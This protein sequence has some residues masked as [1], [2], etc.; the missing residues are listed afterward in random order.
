VIGAALRSQCA[1]CVAGRFSVST[2]ST[3]CSACPPG[4]STSGAEGAV[5]CAYCARGFASAGGQGSCSECEK[6]TYA[7]GEGAARCDQC[8]PGRYA[9]GAKSAECHLCPL[10]RFLEGVGASAQ[11]N[12]TSCT[13]LDKRFFSLAVG[14]T[15]AAA[16]APCPAVRG[17]L[18]YNVRGE[19]CAPCKKGYYCDGSSTLYRCFGKQENC[20]GQAGCAPDFK[21][22]RCSECADDHFL[23]SEQLAWETGDPNATDVVK[24][25][26]PCPNN[27]SMWLLPIFILTLLAVPSLLYAFLNKCCSDTSP[28]NC[29][30]QLSTAVQHVN[31]DHG[32]FVSLLTFHVKF[33][34]QLFASNMLPWPGEFKLFLDAFGGVVPREGCLLRGGFP[35]FASWSTRGGLLLWGVLFFPADYFVLSQEGPPK[36]API[37]GPTSPPVKPVDLP[38]DF[39]PFRQIWRRYVTNVREYEHTL[40]SPIIFQFAAGLFFTFCVKYVAS[41]L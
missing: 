32:T 16:C 30:R 36:G 3:A 31:R 2:G 24:T 29:S 9:D 41:R 40:L 18:T 19:G 4:T 1:A 5:G 33:L 37:L 13:A 39:F 26:K 11:S 8:P 12:C 28:R 35:F 27:S 20:L 21:G 38:V 23:D 14:A 6:G 34:N 17:N 10:G 15:S 7:A 25:C 22:A